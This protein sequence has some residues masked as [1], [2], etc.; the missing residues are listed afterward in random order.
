[1][2]PSVVRPRRVVRPSS[3]VVVLVFPVAVCGACGYLYTHGPRRSVSCMCKAEHR[4]KPFRRADIDTICVPRSHVASPKSHPQDLDVWRSLFT[5]SMQFS[6]SEILALLPTEEEERTPTPAAAAP[7]SHLAPATRAAAAQCKRSPLLQQ[8][9]H[10]SGSS[11]NSA[12]VLVACLARRST[13]SPR[14]QPNLSSAPRPDRT[15]HYFRASRHWR[16][17]RAVHSIL[18]ITVGGVHHYLESYTV[19]VN[20]VQTITINTLQLYKN[21][22]DPL[23]GLL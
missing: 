2:R 15:K 3:P 21:Q 17:Y 6:V 4:P 8:H 7:R 19:G 23:T 12:H 1:M 10:C 18:G 16:V 9:T 11:R 22:R 20:K 5:F 14:C 13:S